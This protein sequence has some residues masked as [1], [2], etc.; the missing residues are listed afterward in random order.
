MDNLDSEKESNNTDPETEENQET[1]SDS[2][3]DDREDDNFSLETVQPS[4]PSSEL[5]QGSINVTMGEYGLKSHNARSRLSV[6]TTI[7]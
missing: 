7:N 3:K 6:Q 5:S 2:E 1:K 4:V